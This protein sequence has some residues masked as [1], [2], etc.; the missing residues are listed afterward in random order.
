MYSGMFAPR[1]AAHL[2]RRAAVVGNKEAAL[3]LAEMGLSKA[4]DSL[5]RTPAMPADPVLPGDY[6]EARSKGLPIIVKRWLDHWLRTPTPAAERLTLFWHGHFTSEYKKVRR[7]LLMWRQSNTFRKLGKGDFAGLLES[8]ARDPAMLIYLDN[9]RSHKQHPNENWGRELLELFTIGVGHYGESDVMAS[10]HAFTGW[11]LTSLKKARESGVS[12]RFAFKKEWH[13]YSPKIF[14]GKQVE[15]GED[16]LEL[17]SSLPQ[18]YLRIASK[19]LRFYLTP[20]P[21][22]EIVEKAADVLRGGGVYEMLRWLFTHEVFY[23]DEVR[24]SL[25]KSPF[26]FLVG[27]LYAAPVRLEQRAASGILATMGQLP[28]QPPGVEGWINGER[29]LEDSPLLVR[30][31]LLARAE[32]LESDLFVFADGYS[33]SPL[34]ASPEAQL[35]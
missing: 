12:P 27:L 4:V 30:M 16:V 8:V 25:T 6:K 22:K 24:L 10:T 32:K 26:E 20:E 29:W 23:Q 9:F 15:G 7:P 17:L 35:L 19:L 28:F 13:D 33:A 14:L 5:L 18:T 21:D 31:K 34:A 11:S 3:G 1:D 2:L